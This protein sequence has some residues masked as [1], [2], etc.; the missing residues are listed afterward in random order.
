MPN[1]VRP[2][3]VAVP[4]SVLEDLGRRL[5]RT[6]LPEEPPLEP[7]S[8]GT[9]VAY[10]RRLIEYWRDGFDWPAQE[11]RKW[12][13]PRHPMRM[14]TDIRRWTVMAKGGHFAALGQP[15]ALVQE[16]RAFFRPLR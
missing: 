1:D 13:P 14:Y 11:T 9:S 16:I 7:W 15:E 12:W 5:S 10:M 8:T 3:R 6:R 4:E 2:F